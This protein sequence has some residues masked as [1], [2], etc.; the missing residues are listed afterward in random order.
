MSLPRRIFKLKGVVQHYSWGGYHFIPQLL[1]IENKEQMPFAEYWLGAHPNHPAFIQTEKKISLNDF[2]SK[3]AQTVLG[4]NVADTFSSLPYLLKILDVRQMLSIQ[5]HPS[6]ASA[7]KGF[8]QENKNKIPVNASHRNYKDENH[9]PELMVALSDFFLLHGFKEEKKL[10]NVL[11]AVPELQFLIDIFKKKNYQGL[12]KEVMMMPQEKVNQVLSTLLQRIVPLYQNGKLK[13]DSEDFWAARAAINFCKNNHYDRGIFSIYFFNLLHLKN[14]E[15]IFQPAGLPHAYLEGQNIEV[16][17]NSD[18]VLRAGLTD[19]HIDVTELMKH[20]KFEGTLPKILS[21]DSDVKTFASP[22][23][24]FELSEY[25]LRKA[26]SFSIKTKTAEIFL[27][28]NGSIELTTEKELMKID[29][30]NP[31]FAVAETVFMM[32]ANENAHVFRVTVPLQ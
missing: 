26:S 19:K 28:L 17:A 15:G 12:Y 20:V 7:E 9:K 14:G 6:K 18:N 21:Y 30:G 31:F 25:Q 29:K 2:I 27:V 22:A 24:E 3:D 11:N 5:V 13:N 8:D 23:K 32:K 16:M 10:I 4:K 1:N